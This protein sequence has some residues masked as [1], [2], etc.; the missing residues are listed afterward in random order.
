MWILRRLG[1]SERKRK[2]LAVI[3]LWHVP[4]WKKIFHFS[5]LRGW[6]VG[7]LGYGDREALDS[8]GDAI[9]NPERGLHLWVQL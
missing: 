7:D 2:R 5:A 6:G 4:G 8:A 3:G 9:S 1:R